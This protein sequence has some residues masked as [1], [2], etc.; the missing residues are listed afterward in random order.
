MV[1]TKQARWV[2]RV[3]RNFYGCLFLRI[4]HFSVSRELIFATIVGVMKQECSVI[5]RLIL[6]LLNFLIINSFPRLSD[7]T[8]CGFHSKYSNITER[9][10]TC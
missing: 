8:D 3:A 4:G 1:D 10:R 5:V 6:L 9:K 2:Y 7:F